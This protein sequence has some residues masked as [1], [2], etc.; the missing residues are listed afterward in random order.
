MNRGLTPAIWPHL[1]ACFVLI[2]CMT[3]LTT[4]LNAAEATSPDDNITA[5]LPQISDAKFILTDFGA[6]GDGK[7]LNTDAFKSAV[8]AIAKAGGGHLIVSVLSL[9]S[10]TAWRTGF[11]R[12]AERL[13]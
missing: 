11:V 2:C 1:L 3:S 5:A 6:I 9:N 13:L 12:V 7:T 8:A 4:A 10:F